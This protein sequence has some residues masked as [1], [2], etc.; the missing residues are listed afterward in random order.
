[1]SNLKTS[2]YYHKA[3]GV[4]LNFVIFVNLWVGQGEPRG[5][6]SPT[7]AGK[8]TRT[9]HTADCK[10]IVLN[11]KWSV[12][13]PERL[14]LKNFRGEPRRLFYVFCQLRSGVAASSPSVT[15]LQSVGG[16]NCSLRRRARDWRPSC[17]AFSTVWQHWQHHSPPLFSLDRW[18]RA[19]ELVDLGDC[20]LKAASLG[21]RPARWT[22]RAEMGVEVTHANS[23]S[24]HRILPSTADV[25]ILCHLFSSW[26]SIPFSFGQ[27][28]LWLFGSPSQSSKFGNCYCWV[29]SEC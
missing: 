7:N 16:P 3:G 24:F 27:A 11:G 25:A 28:K 4:I 20:V 29:A 26:L 14:L 9:F 2:L 22:R 18:R 6:S 8:V 19:S 13:A 10:L 15:T 21:G 12:R 17:A 23:L 5:G 1:M